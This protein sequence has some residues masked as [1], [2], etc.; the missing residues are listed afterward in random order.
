MMTDE[1]SLTDKSTE[2]RS[3]YRDD[4]GRWNAEFGQW[5]IV[6]TIRQRTYHIYYRRFVLQYIFILSVFLGRSVYFEHFNY[7]EL[8]LQ[9]GMTC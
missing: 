9:V 1:T 4:S 5:C 2:Q 6:K 7:L 3:P 8:M